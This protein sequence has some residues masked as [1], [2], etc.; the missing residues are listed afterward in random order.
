MAGSRAGSLQVANSLLVLLGRGGA[1][2]RGQLSCALSRQRAVG[3]DSAPLVSRRSFAL[4]AAGGSPGGVQR[5]LLRP[6]ALT[7]SVGFGAL[8]GRLTRG[9]WRP[10]P[11]L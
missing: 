8:H 4:S 2:C 9:F 5:V 6:A 11:G 3:R 7:G 10:R 1:T